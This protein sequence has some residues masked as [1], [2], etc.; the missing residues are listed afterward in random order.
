MTVDPQH[1]R[2]VPEV[3]PRPASAPAVLGRVG[4]H[5]GDREVG[6]RLD[7][8]RRTAGQVDATPSPCSRRPGP[9]PVRRRRARGRRAPAGGCRGPDR[10]ARSA[11][12]PTPRA[13]RP[14]ARG[15]PPG[16]PRAALDR[17][18]GHAHGHQPGL[19]PVVQVP[20]DAPQL[21]GLRV[22]GVGPGLGE[23]AHPLLQRAW[24]S[25]RAASGCRGR[26]AARPGARSGSPATTRPAA[27]RRRRPAPRPHRSGR[28]RRSANVP[29]GQSYGG[30]GEDGQSV[31]P[32]SPGAVRRGRPMAGATSS[33]RRSRHVA[34]SDSTQFTRRSHPSSAGADRRGRPV[35]RGDRDAGRT[36]G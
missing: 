22:E 33:H 13:P 6:G 7:R 23:L 18:E 8:R 34:G 28:G 19:R 21:R 16:R 30:S 26:A 31:A 5:L 25:G 15:P 1:C 32:S 3:E 27:E 10:A 29:A 9:A 4:Q 14:A 36:R 17:A 35:S 11:P 24:A 12:S 2:V 20:L